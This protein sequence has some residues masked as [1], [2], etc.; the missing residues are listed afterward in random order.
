M[1]ASE[2]GKKC[3]SGSTSF[4]VPSLNQAA[5]H[6]PYSFVLPRTNQ[7]GELNIQYIYISFFSLLWLIWNNTK[8]DTQ[9]RAFFV[10]AIYFSYKQILGPLAGV[11]YFRILNFPTLFS[12]PLKS[13]QTHLEIHS[14]LCVTVFWD[15][16]HTR[17]PVNHC[18]KMYGSVCEQKHKRIWNMPISKCTE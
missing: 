12:D 7:W 18:R 1:Q 6:V 16:T 13:S 9:K 17:Q 2:S 14:Q 3:C 10:S 4:E 5:C 8:W 15:L 11:P